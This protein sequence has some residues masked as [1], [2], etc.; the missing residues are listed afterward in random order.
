MPQK[1]DEREVT[2]GNVIKQAVP[3]SQF[4]AMLITMQDT[5]IC[6]SMAD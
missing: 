2:A 1:E 3:S 5:Y 4:R 6:C